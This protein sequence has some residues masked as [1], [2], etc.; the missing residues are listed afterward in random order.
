MRSFIKKLW[1]TNS[2]CKKLPYHVRQGKWGEKKAVRY[3]RKNGYRIEAK[4]VFFHNL[5]ELDIIASRKKTVIF[6][7]VKTRKNIRYGRPADAV[8]TKKR[9]KLERCAMRYLKQ[10]HLQ[11]DYIRF[12]VIEVIGECAGSLHHRLCI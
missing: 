7:E 4:N 5:G 12:D 1:S 3:L 11:P 10:R 8:N 2:W 9:R 6:V